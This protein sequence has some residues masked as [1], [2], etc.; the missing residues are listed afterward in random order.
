[1]DIDL[2]DADL[3]AESALPTV[4]VDSSGYLLDADLSYH[5]FRPISISQVVFQVPTLHLHNYAWPSLTKWSNIQ[6]IGTET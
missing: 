5:A 3:K 1:V 2:S 4:Q 6:V